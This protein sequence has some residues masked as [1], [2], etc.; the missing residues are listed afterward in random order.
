MAD[1]LR[2]CQSVIMQNIHI[3]KTKIE[4]KICQTCHK[5]EKIN[6]SVV[7]VDTCQSDRE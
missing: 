4:A 2:Q 7:C 1:F 3:M 5:I 6:F